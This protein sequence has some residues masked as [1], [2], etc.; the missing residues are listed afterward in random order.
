MIKYSVFLRLAGR[1]FL[2]LIGLIILFFLLVCTSACIPHTAIAEHV[3]SSADILE[4]EGLYPVSFGN[5]YSSL[6]FLGRDQ[7][8]DCLMLNLAIAQDASV[9]LESAITSPCLKGTYDLDQMPSNLRRLADGSVLPD[10]NY[11]WY[12]H[13]YLVIL[14]P[15]LVFFDYGQIRWINCVLMLLL[16]VWTLV[17]VARKIGRAE[18]LLLL[19]ALLMMHYET[20]P[21]T[22]Q[23]ASV[24]FV[25]FL[26]I[27]ILLS[28]P[29]WFFRSGHDYMAFFSIGAVTVF[30]DFLTA[31]VVSLG[32]P[33]LIWLLYKNPPDK[34][35]Q[36]ILF[37]VAWGLGYAL[38]W[39]S[40]W[41]I[42]AVSFDP[43]VLQHAAEHADK[44][45]G[46]D[47]EAGRLAMTVGVFKKYLALLWSM[48]WLWCLCVAAV[49]LWIKSG[50]QQMRNNLWLLLVAVIP[51]VW[52]LV[53][54]NHN[55]VHFG[56]TW[57][58]IVVTLYAMALLTYRSVSNGSIR[59]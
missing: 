6:S 44:W 14:K 38:L 35:R 37:S 39:M 5:K 3:K 25:T 29:K 16:V 46:N 4:K 21:Y 50:I 32:L 57:R 13:G 43:L 22:M 23:F 30:V 10:T 26:A 15:L 45:G 11:D 17:L 34:A 36:V 18:M 8:T 51:F 1:F 41:A 48:N 2:C 55:F 27:I 28:F 24:F 52:S 47:A 42:C 49:L 53:L 33:L 59:K 58:L 7:Y 9:P 54:V 40:K 31:P 20:V 56:F 12:W 19:A